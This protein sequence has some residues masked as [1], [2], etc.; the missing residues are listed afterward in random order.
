MD[1]QL[2]AVYY[3]I[4]NP[5]A[6]SSAE[7]LKTF[8]KR[9]NKPVL[10]KAIE[11]W[12][13]SQKAYTLH[14]QRRLNFK[15]NKYNMANI[16]D[17]WQADLMDMQSLSRLNKGFR[18]ILTVIDCFSKFGWCIPIKKKNPSEIMTGFQKILDRCHYK[19]YRLHTDKGGEFVNTRVKQFLKEKDIAHY[20]TTDPVTKA[21]ICERFI[22][23]MK[24]IIYRY[25]T[26]TGTQKYYDVLDSLVTMYNNRFHR[27]IGMPPAKVNECNVLKV[28]ENLNEKSIPKKPPKLRPGDFVR[29]AKPKGSFD[30][31]YKPVWSSEIFAVKKAI[32]HTYPVYKIQDLEGEEIIGSFY[33]AELQKVTR[34]NRLD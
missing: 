24:T 16:G 11:L 29:L 27:S 21:S 25:F 33:E 6:F 7:R 12:L 9:K 31:G 14:K 13:R 28:W 19:P 8:F 3:N 4:A 1:K 2:S 34:N 15:R 22:R 18:Y 32:R 17:I 23:T 5:A 30:K 10:V 26:Y 20:L